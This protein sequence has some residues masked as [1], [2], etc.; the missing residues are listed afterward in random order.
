[1][2]KEGWIKKLG[3]KGEGK[4]GGVGAEVWVVSGGGCRWESRIFW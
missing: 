1:M 3:K 4:T 2:R